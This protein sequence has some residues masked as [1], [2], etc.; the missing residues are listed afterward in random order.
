MMGA[1]T[2]RGM[3][4]PIALKPGDVVAYDTQ[5][6]VVDSETTHTSPSVSWVEWELN[7]G[8]VERRLTL[9]LVGERLFGGQPARVAGRPGDETVAGEG[10]TF[11]LRRHGKADVRTARASGPVAFDRVEF[12]HYT[13]EA[14]RLVIICR[15]HGSERSVSLVPT[16]E[17]ALQVYSV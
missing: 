10:V 6:C 14:G 12:W 1:T 11:T 2:E 8:S 17:A 7:P 13:S 9:V 4:P 15:S 3:G 16:S 5:D